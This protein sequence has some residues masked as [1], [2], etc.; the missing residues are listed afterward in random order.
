ML[1]GRCKNAIGLESLLTPS[2]YDLVNLSIHQSN[3]HSNNQNDNN[4]AVI[5][6]FIL[7]N[8]SQSQLNPISITNSTNSNHLSNLNNLLEL[9]SS[10]NENKIELPICLECSDNLGPLLN[11]QLS[12]LRKER[13]KLIQYQSDYL[14]QRANAVTVDGITP[15]A[16][17][18]KEIAKL[19]KAQVLATVELTRLEQEKDQLKLELQALDQE[20]AA[21]AADENQ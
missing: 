2:T 4:Q 14:K 16:L 1:C 8:Q 20:E 19:H 18:G 13:D 12:Q 7:L 17:L 10:T 21:L 5:E 6:S 15:K 3:N 11:N 9:I